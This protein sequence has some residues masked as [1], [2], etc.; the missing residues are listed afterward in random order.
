MSDCL[1]SPAFQNALRL[2]V[3]RDRTVWQWWENTALVAPS[4]DREMFYA[5]RKYAEQK[6]KGRQRPLVPLIYAALTTALP[7]RV[8][9]N[10]IRGCDADVAWDIF[11]DLSARALPAVSAQPAVPLVPEVASYVARGDAASWR[12]SKP[13]PLATAMR[14]MHVRG[15]LHA[16]SRRLSA[17]REVEADADDPMIG[18]LHRASGTKMN[19]LVD[20]LILFVLTETYPSGPFISACMRCRG[21]ALKLVKGMRKPLTA[22]AR[23]VLARRFV[24][25]I[26]D[27]V[28][29]CCLV[30]KGAVTRVVEYIHGT[31]EPHTKRACTG[32]A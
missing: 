6:F 3:A 5:L 14:S 31:E 22:E 15:A 23:E 24:G 28:T 30:E 11:E 21:D 29:A 2:I 17:L 1:N 9:V 26:F 16:V 19:K 10:T 13:G 27:L 20:E 32:N 7:P 8:S 4:D 18:R 12:A 25:A